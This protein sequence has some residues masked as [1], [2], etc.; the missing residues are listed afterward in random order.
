MTRRFPGGFFF[1]LLK[2]CMMTLNSGRIDVH[3]HMI[4]DFYREAAAAA[5]RRPALSSGLPAW[6]PGAALGVMDRAAIAT[7]ITSI[8]APGVH[9]GDDLAAQTL[10]R[11]CNEF[12][13]ELAREHPARFGGFAVLPLPHIEYSLEE[14][15]YALDTLH[16]DGILLFAN[17]QGRY[18]GDP[19]FDPLLDELNRRNCVT[20]IHPAPHPGVAALGTDLPQFVIEYVFDTTRAATNMIFSETLLRFPNIRFILAH[21]GGTLPYIAWRVAHSPQI[22]PNRFGVIP[23]ESIFAQLEHFWYDTA[24]SVSPQALAGLAQRYRRRPHPLRQR[25]AL[26]AGGAHAGDGRGPE[27]RTID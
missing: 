12:A 27:Q 16:L 1:H 13:A 2:L 22:D 18:L 10:A 24:L 25:L 4:P 19:Q 11:R 23:P 5:G 3:F 21:A 14:V 17:C 20:F 9:F 26:C 8:S 15:R 7:A 6:S